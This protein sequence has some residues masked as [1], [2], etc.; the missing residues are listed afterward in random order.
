MIEQIKNKVE[1]MF[2]DLVFEEG[3]HLYFVNGSHFPS[4]SSLIKKHETYVDFDS[5]SKAVAIRDNKSQKQVQKE[6]TKIKD[7]ACALGTE[8]HNYAE[9]YDG[10]QEPKNDLQRAAKKFFDELPPYYE[11]ISKEIRMYSR[12]YK[13]AGTA[14]L[15]LLDTRTNSLVIADFKTN[16]DLWKSYQMLQ[17]PFEHLEQNNFNKYQFQLSYYQIILEQTGYDVSNRVIVWLRRDGEYE[18]HST[19]DY[20]KELRKCLLNRD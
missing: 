3:K 5:I 11:I 19:T 7:D 13:Y 18:I 8:T 12:E 1:W 9:F 6:W 14:D 10:T 17:P 2:S 20:T 4:V 16:K 15:L